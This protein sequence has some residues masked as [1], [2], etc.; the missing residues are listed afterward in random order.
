MSLQEELLYHV[1]CGKHSRNLGVYGCAM[2]MSRVI[3]EL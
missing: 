2:M 3:S 1:L